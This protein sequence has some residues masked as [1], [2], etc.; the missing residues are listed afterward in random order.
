M[1]NVTAKKSMW[2]DI[3][4]Q[5]LA[6]EL[7]LGRPADAVGRSLHL[8]EWCCEK[9]S[10]VVTRQVADMHLGRGGAAALVACELGQEVE[11]GILVLEAVEEVEAWKAR[12]E[13]WSR[14]GEKRSKSSPRDAG[15]FRSESDNRASPTP[16]SLSSPPASDQVETSQ[17]PANHQPSTSSAPAS[18]QPEPALSSSSPSSPHSHNQN[19]P[20][21]PSKG[22]TSGRP[23]KGFTEA[24][25]AAATRTLAH[26][27]RRTGV[28]YQASEAHVRL[29]TARLRE[30]GVTEEDLRKV[31]AFCWDKNGLNWREKT[32]D[33]GE[34]MAVHLCPQTLF[35]PKKLHAYL[36]RARSWFDTHV[37]PGLEQQAS[38]DG[39]RAPPAATSASPVPAPPL[40]HLRKA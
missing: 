5:M 18:N 40:V 10:A 11:G 8:I 16:A 25:V 26:I 31:V 29:I 4:Y 9:R 20:F 1:P 35:G 36:D 7:E 12:H 19:P 38:G 27:T 3:R 23:R 30:E 37:A 33:S 28:Q 24:E 22:G 34:R 2:G 32:T 6:G 21:P 39:P 13:G 14:G 15:Q 17:E